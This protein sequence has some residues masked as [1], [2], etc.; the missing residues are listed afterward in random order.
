MSWNHVSPTE[1]KKVANRNHDIF[2]DS[3]NLKSF[4][5]KVANF[6]G[7]GID[8]FFLECTTNKSKYHEMLL[9][10]I[11][12]RFKNIGFKRDRDLERVFYRVRDR[13]EKIWSRRTLA[14]TQFSNYSEPDFSI[15]KGREPSKTW[16]QL[17]WNGLSRRFQLIQPK[18][19]HLLYWYYH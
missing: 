17:R 4:G 10:T 13:D 19:S 16:L 11:F 14:S 8:L 7:S 3:L 1:L 18:S 5:G 9:K 2:W 6:H 15:C 12:V